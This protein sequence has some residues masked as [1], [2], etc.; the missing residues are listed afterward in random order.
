MRR[1]D[2]ET[3]RTN[4]QTHRRLRGGGRFASGVVALGGDTFHSAD[5]TLNVHNELFE[6][7][8]ERLL[9]EKVERVAGRRTRGLNA[10]EHGLAHIFD[11]LED[12][13]RRVCA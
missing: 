8:A 2:G 12:V 1:R 7:V 3:R 13:L 6:A 5:K 9:R 11:S 4:H 10:V